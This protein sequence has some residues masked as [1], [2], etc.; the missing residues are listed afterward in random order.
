MP[1]DGNVSRE[2]FESRVREWAEDVAPLSSPTSIM[3][4][5]AFLELL[6]YGS[7]IVPLAMKMIDECPIEMI[8]LLHSVTGEIPIKPGNEG[9]VLEMVSDWKRWWQDNEESVVF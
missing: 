4:H 2:E 7:N 8:L 5:P 9:K 6:Q 1:F 3:E